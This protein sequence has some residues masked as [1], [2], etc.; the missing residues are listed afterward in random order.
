LLSQSRNYG[1]VGLGTIYTSM[2]FLTVIVA[3][4]AWVTFEGERTGKPDPLR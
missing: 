2:A 3:L 1:G 4:V